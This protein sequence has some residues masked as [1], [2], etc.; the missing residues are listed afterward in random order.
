MTN[1]EQTR[2]AW[3]ECAAAYDRALTDVDMRAAERALQLSHVG[4]GMRLLDIAAGPGALSI[5]AARLGADVLAVDYS[6]AM[7]RLLRR[8]SAAL[9]LSNLHAQV[10]DGM[11][12]DLEDDQFDIACSALGIML[13]PD[14][15]K[16]LREMTRVIRLGGTGVMVVL[17]PPRA[18]PVMSLFF[19]AMQRTVPGF[20]PPRDSPLFCLQDPDVLKDEMRQ[21]GLQDVRVEPFESTLN[22]PS[23]AQLWEHLMAG[24]PALAGIMRA[25][26]AER[27][28]AVRTAYL[29]FVRTRF[30]AGPL[31]IPMMFNI[32]VGTKA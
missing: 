18:V 5:P 6:Q 30:G 3:E 28:P 16:G 1:L 24:A 7:V 23:D 19:E 22:V 31:S 11:A 17:G 15:A 4:P 27:Q 12:L 2:Q 21:S 32:G 14:R 26:P 9:G 29:D 20:A 13:F 10:M 25:V 8:K